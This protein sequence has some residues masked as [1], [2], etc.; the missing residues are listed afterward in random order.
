M[1]QCLPQSV[2]NRF[3][4]Q[5]YLKRYPDVAKAGV[6]AAEHFLHYGWSEGRWPAGFG[7]LE[8]DDEIWAEQEPEKCEIQLQNIIQLQSSPQSGL[9]AWFLCRWLA[10]WGRWAEAVYFLPTL[11]DDQEALSLI[12]HQGPFLLAFS[13]YWNL[14][15]YKNLTS[16]FESPHWID[17]DDKTLARSMLD[18]GAIR[19]ERINK[20]FHSNGLAGIA[21][22]KKASLDDIRPAPKIEGAGRLLFTPTVSIIIPCFNAEKT[23]ATALRSLCEQTYRK[24][25]V[26]L[27]NDASTD[28]TF[29]VIQQ[30]MAKDNRIRYIELPHN[31][32]AYEARNVG[33][34]KAKGSLITTHDADDW[35]HPEKIALQVKALRY[36]RKAI[37]CL[38][39]WVRCDSELNFKRWRIEDG[40]IHRNMSSLMF[41]RK[42]HRKLGFWDNVSVNADT[43]FLYRIIQTFGNARVIDVKP[44]VPLAF[45]RVEPG[46]LTQ[47][48]ATHIST[49]FCGLRK[50]YMDAAHAWH[51]NSRH[52]YMPKS[53]KRKF[54]VPPLMC[55]GSDEIQRDNLKAWLERSGL[56][57]SE[58][59]RL[60]YPDVAQAKIPPLNH[61]VNHGVDEGREPVPQFCLSAFAFKNG[62]N[63]YDALCLLASQ[64]TL[65]QE[66]IAVSGEMKVKIGKPHIL[67]VGHL[68]QKELFG[69]ERSFLDSIRMLSNFDFNLH[70][71]LPSAENN[72]YLNSIRACSVGV[73]FLPLPWW[74]LGRKVSLQTVDKIKEL[75][76]KTKAEVVYSNT[77]TLWEPLVAAKE[78]RVKSVVHIRELPGQDK[79]LCERLGGNPQEI[80]QHVISIADHYIANSSTTASYYSIPDVTDTVPNAVDLRCY[81]QEKKQFNTRFSA[82]MISSNIKKKGIEDLYEIAKLSE[83]AD[84]PIDFIVC[85]PKTEL[86]SSLSNQ[87]NLQN[88]SYEGY[89][90]NIPSILESADILLTLSHFPESFGRTV[91]EAMAAGCVVV[92]YDS[93]AVSEL[94]DHSRGVLIGDRDVVQVFEKLS[95]LVSRT[96]VMQELSNNAKHYIHQNY[97][98]TAI[99]NKLC[100]VFEQ[101]VRTG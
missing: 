47:T 96:A 48:G 61:F 97:S 29:E 98:Y 85:G 14:K 38:S 87:Y 67:L 41:R 95:W 25:E 66:C 7:V 75:I 63:N 78:K 9:A 49:Q 3:D 22:N 86:L 18:D 65:P 16:L 58:W 33:L 5:W 69:A 68:A 50:E 20:V 74:R 55:R 32:G 24:I 12:K 51:N 46:S 80:L 6:D 88:L 19:I 53:G 23:L 94:V 99:G 82:V 10:S 79:D 57:D 92:G 8:V 15:Q 21:V 59:Y 26:I 30:F 1:S 28:N 64:N 81:S 84:I 37:A 45:G 34:S 31:R 11:L 100:S 62:L 83:A 77:I 35:S 43:E 89:V 71:L 4:E 40:W 27:V 44:G 90:E 36:N 39:H 42:V 91:A 60:M 2:L 56:F 101:L 70:V 17:T 54:K 13:T 72:N 73:Y 52:L 93:G 76:A